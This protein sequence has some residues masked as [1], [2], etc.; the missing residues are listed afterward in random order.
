M[1]HKEIRIFI[2]RLTE[3]F[4]TPMYSLLLCIRSKPIQ[5]AKRMIH[6]KNFSFLLGNSLC[7]CLSKEFYFHLLR[8]MQRILYEYHY[9]PLHINYFQNI[10]NYNKKIIYSFYIIL[11]F[12]LRSILENS[13]LVFGIDQII[14]FIAIYFLIKEFSLKKSN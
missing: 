1:D 11:I 8:M 3:N 6:I 9:F 4:T 7:L 10:N 14:F 5:P 13:F 2:E 12:L